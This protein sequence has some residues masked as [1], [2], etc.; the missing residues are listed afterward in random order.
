MYRLQLANRSELGAHHSV[1]A[2]PQLEAQERRMQLSSNTI[3]E[4]LADNPVRL[5][6][7]HNCFSLKLTDPAVQSADPCV[8]CVE[9]SVEL[10]AWAADDCHEPR[11]AAPKDPTVPT[12]RTEPSVSHLCHALQ[13]LLQPLSISSHLHIEP[14]H[15]NPPGLPHPPSPANGLL[16]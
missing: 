2:E 3:A 12:K 9:F 14:L 11:R 5:W 7:S 4:F 13:L 6:L 1:A 15:N 16:L 8:A 10:L